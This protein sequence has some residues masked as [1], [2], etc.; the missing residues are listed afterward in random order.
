[1]TTV[2]PVS[3]LRLKAGGKMSKASRLILTLLSAAVIMAALTNTSTARNL[4]SSSGTIRATWGELVFREP[5]GQTV[6]CAVTLE[7][8]LHSRTIV[9]GNYN[10]IGNVTRA[11]LVEG[12]CT[13]GTATIRRESLPWNVRYQGFEGTLPRISKIFLLVAGASFRARGGFGTCE[14]TTRET[15]TEH[16]RGTFVRNTATGALETVEVGGSITSNDNCGPFG[17]RIRGTLSSAS[18]T[19][20]VLGAS[21]PI[22]VTLI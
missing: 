1:M 10:L 8:S 2:T 4:S 6:K 9:K 12:N 3:L 11:E 18:N 7:G 17:E 21:T 5:L 15:L 14:F 13:N 19:L 22:T 20:T 16:G